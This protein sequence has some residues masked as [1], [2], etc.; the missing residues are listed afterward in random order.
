MLEIEVAYHKGEYD[1][2]KKQLMEEKT[3]RI[4]LSKELYEKEKEINSLKKAASQSKKK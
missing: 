1:K 2:V 3:N 4:A